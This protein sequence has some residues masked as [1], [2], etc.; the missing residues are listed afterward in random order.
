MTLSRHAD[1]APR[2]TLLLAITDRSG[3]ADAR[4]DLSS[5]RAPS[6][7]TTSSRPCSTF[8][9]APP[10]CSQQFLAN[11]KLVVVV[12]RVPVPLAP[13]EPP[14]QVR[15]AT[16]EMTFHIKFDDPS[17]ST[18]S[19]VTP[20]LLCCISHLLLDVCI[21]RPCLMSPTTASVSH[22]GMAA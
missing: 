20:P 12:A 14:S 8:T 6:R 17:L 3:A 19:A 16:A 10:P 1:A 18:R 7:P 5:A 2:Q 21:S 4:C 9:S 13:C 15:S 22:P 11:F